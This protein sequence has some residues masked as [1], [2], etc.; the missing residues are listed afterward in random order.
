MLMAKILILKGFN[1][2]LTYSRFWASQPAN[3]ENTYL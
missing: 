1:S 2:E 3:V